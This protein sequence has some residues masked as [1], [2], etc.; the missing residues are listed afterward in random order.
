M[1]GHGEY[2]PAHGGIGKLLK[3]SEIRAELTDRAEMVVALYRE[4]VRKDT[5]E[6]ARNVRVH[7]EIGGRRGDRWTAVVTAHA[8]HAAARE[9][10]NYRRRGKG[11]GGEH[12]LRDIGNEMEG[13]T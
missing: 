10:G 1:T 13:G 12:V 8:G 5:G 4:R 3:G 11:F 9:F 2:T 7:T 6:N